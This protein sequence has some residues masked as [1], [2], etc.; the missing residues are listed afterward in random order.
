MLGAAQSEITRR[1]DNR[2]LQTGQMIRDL[3]PPVKEE[4]LTPRLG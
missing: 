2:E 4:A 3:K 1:D